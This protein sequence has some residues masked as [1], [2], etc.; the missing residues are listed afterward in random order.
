MTIAAADSMAMIVPRTQ[1]PEFP[2]LLRPEGHDGEPI[3][4]SRGHPERR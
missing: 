4:S 3:R 1:I 2:Y